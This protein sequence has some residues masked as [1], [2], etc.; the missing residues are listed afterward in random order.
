MGKLCEKVKDLL[1]DAAFGKKNPA[2]T[3]KPEDAAKKP[4]D[5]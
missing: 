3:L 2:D 1:S 4:E 5:K